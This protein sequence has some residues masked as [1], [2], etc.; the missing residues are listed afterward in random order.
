MPR[1]PRIAMR[2]VSS[3]SPGCPRASQC[4]GE[5]F[6]CG[7]AYWFE[8]EPARHIGI[9]HA[10]TQHDLAP[11][12]DHALPV[13]EQKRKCLERGMLPQKTAADYYHIAGRNREKIALVKVPTDVLDPQQEAVFHRVHVDL[14]RQGSPVAG[15]RIAYVV[16][17]GVRGIKAF[18]AEQLR[19]PGHIGVFP[20]NK[21]IRVEELAADGDVVDHFAPVERGGSRG[22]EYIFVIAEV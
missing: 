15:Q 21:K 18:P 13:P 20:V 11:L 5:L 22:A 2:T 9:V 12:G 17:P 4:G 7:F 19:A 14:G 8:V 6:G 3:L 10:L 1:V 16:A